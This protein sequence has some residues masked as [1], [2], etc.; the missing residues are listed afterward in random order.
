MVPA[1]VTSTTSWISEKRVLIEYGFRT[2]FCSAYLDWD[3]AV[4]TV[5]EP[6]FWFVD[7]F[8]QVIGPVFVFL[9]VSLTVVFVLIAYTI[10]VPYWWNRSPNT[11]FAVLLVGHWILIN[12]VFNYYMALTTCPGLPPRGV[13]LPETAS[14]CRKCVSPRPPR[15][16]H[17]SVCNTCILKMDHHCPWLNQC[18]GH[19]NHRFFFLYMVYMTLGTCLVMLFGFDIMWSELVVDWDA[20][21]EDSAPLLIPLGNDT[22][23]VS[24]TEKFPLWNVQPG[25]PLRRY[26]VMLESL[27]SAGVFLALGALSVW[28]GR[29]ISRGETSIEAHINAKETKRLALWNQVYSN[30]YD[31]GVKRNW[32]LFLGLDGRSLRHLLLPSTHLPYSDGL[33][34]RHLYT[35]LD[36]TPSRHVKQP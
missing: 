13:L 24:Q 23:G 6:A 15:T 17:C 25:S 36:T 2:L 18:V 5:L 10:G 29:L 33:T 35:N 26:F 34:W 19:Y 22:A 7:N 14:V 9:V 28:H 4:D 31:R 3:Y 16:H 20:P 8:T 12:V 30:P 21:G 32:I 1:I 27:L 11:L